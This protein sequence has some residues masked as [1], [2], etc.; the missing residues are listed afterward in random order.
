MNILVCFHVLAIVNSTA[1][2]VGVHVS[3]S[4]KVFFYWYMP[5]SGI[6]G[7]Y[8]SSMFSFLRYFHA[9]FHSDYTNLQLSSGDNIPRSCATAVYLW[10]HLRLCT[11]FMDMTLILHPASL[12]LHRSLLILKKETRTCS[13]SSFFEGVATREKSWHIFK[14]L[15]GQDLEAA[16]AEDFGCRMYLRLRPCPTPRGFWDQARGLE[17]LQQG[18]Q[19]LLLDR[20]E[21]CHPWDPAWASPLTWLAPSGGLCVPSGSMWCTPGSPS[22]LH[23]SCLLVVQVHAVFSAPHFLLLIPA[24]LLEETVCVPH[25]WKSQL[26]HF[27]LIRAHFRTHLGSPSKACKEQWD[28]PGTP[29]QGWVCP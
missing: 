5:R 27:P 15:H 3:F 8:G 14:T 23:H 26:Y 20:A 2:N 7:S 11:S 29:S 24:L 12:P 4:V 17:K 18:R 22:S 1:M 19:S 25:H 9:V 6:P 21:V 16:I 28:V 13:V 10:V